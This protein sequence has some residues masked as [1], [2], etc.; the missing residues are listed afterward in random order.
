MQLRKTL[1]IGLLA[2][3]L[4]AGCSSEQDNVTMSPLPEVQSQFTPYVVWDKSVGN[5]I[6][7]Y[8]S[9]LSPAWDGSV[10]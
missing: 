2:S 10:V 8:Y 5:G 9:H 1:L 3:A 7:K 6:G 4:L